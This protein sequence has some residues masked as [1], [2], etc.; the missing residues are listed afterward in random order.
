M[1]YKVGDK[2]RVKGELSVR[3]GTGITYAVKDMFKYRSKIMTIKG[4]RK[5]IA[6]D[7]TIY[8]LDDN[9]EDWA[10]TEEMFEP[11]CKYKVGDRVVVRHDLS[12]DIKKFI[13]TINKCFMYTSSS[14]KF[15]VGSLHFLLKGK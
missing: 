6:G 9:G 7:Y 5:T 12:L 15:L 4:M 14:M 13:I 1:K 8:T 2:V 10:W 11:A 3:D